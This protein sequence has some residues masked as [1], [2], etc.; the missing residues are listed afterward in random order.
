MTCVLRAGVALA[1][2]LGADPGVALVV[3]SSLSEAMGWMRFAPLLSLIIFVVAL[4]I[5][6]SQMIR[7]IRAMM[8]G[9]TNGFINAALRGIE[10][11]KQ[12]QE[13]KAVVEEKAKSMRCASCGAVSVIEPGEPEI[14]AYCG[15]PL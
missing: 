6:I 3:R 11:P 13:A 7:F 10:T 9:M 2:C 14:C 1:S 8:H 4:V 5:T 12:P 15:S